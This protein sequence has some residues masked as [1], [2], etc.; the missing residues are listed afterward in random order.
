M[1]DIIDPYFLN[2]LDLIRQILGIGIPETNYK[3]A[4]GIFSSRKNKLGLK[5]EEYLNILITDAGEQ[6]E[7][8]NKATKNE[9]YF[10]REEKKFSVL[11]ECVLPNF[12]MKDNMKFWSATCSTGEMAV[13]LALLARNYFG[14]RTL[15]DITVYAITVR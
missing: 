6:E 2:N 15:K 3:V 9:T 10:F 12:H 14:D 13:S 11:K 7:F 5:D 4:S 1:T 8:I